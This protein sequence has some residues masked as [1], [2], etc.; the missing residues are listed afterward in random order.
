MKEKFLKDYTDKVVN[1]K[2]NLLSLLVTTPANKFEV[3]MVVGKDDI[4]KK[5]EYLDNTYSDEFTHQFNDKVI[6]VDYHFSEASVI[7]PSINYLFNT[8]LKG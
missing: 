5:V 8:I 4:T 6:I 1:G 3:I 7:N 2:S